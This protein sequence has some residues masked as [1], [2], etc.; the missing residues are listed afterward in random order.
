MPCQLP[1]SR[2]FEPPWNRPGTIILPC[3]PP[4]NR[5][6]T[7]LDP[8]HDPAHRFVAALEQPWGQGTCPPSEPGILDMSYPLLVRRVIL[9]NIDPL[10]IRRGYP[11]YSLSG[12]IRWLSV[13]YPEGVILDKPYPC[14]SRGWW[15]FVHLIRC[16]FWLILPYLGVSQLF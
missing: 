2:A 4:W 6:G 8:L 1:W 3:Q 14:L 5:L 7:A 12:V 16:G 10:V 13:A 15:F 11:G 9:D